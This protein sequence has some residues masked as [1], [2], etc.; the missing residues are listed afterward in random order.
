MLAKVRQLLAHEFTVAEL[1]GIAFL[2][3]ASYLA[4]GAFWAFTHPE[5]LPDTG[6]IAAVASFLGAVVSWPVLL[7]SDVCIA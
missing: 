7:L 4:V 3:T 6:G 1:V 5:R 2:L